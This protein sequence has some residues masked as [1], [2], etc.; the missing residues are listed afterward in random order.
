MTVLDWGLL[1]VWLGVAL[2]GFWKGAIRIV[3]GLGGAAAGLWLAIVAGPDLTITLEEYT[4]S[5][6][7]AMVL[8]YLLPV[9]CCLL[10]CIAA[11]WGLERTMMALHLSWLNRLVGALLAGLTAALMM[12][13]ILVYAA[14]YSPALAELCRRSLLTPYLL[15]LLELLVPPAEEATS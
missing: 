7:L 14:R 6:W 3:F 13:V 11:G 4:H 1:L 2:C 12:A 8:G 9:V 10:I 15:E 5:T